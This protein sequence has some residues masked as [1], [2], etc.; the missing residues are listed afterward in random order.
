MELIVTGGGRGESTKEIDKLF[1]SKLDKHKPLL[2]IPIAID[3]IKHPYSECLNWLKGTFNQFGVS[4]YEMWI[5]KDLIKSK[6]KNPK[7]YSGIYIGGG[8]T[9][10]L[11]FKLKESGFWDFLKKALASDIPI[12]GSSAGAA[13]FSKTISI[14]LAYDKNW[15]NLSDLNGMN[16]IS[17]YEITCHFSDEERKLIQELI[18][19]HKIKHL[20]AL[21]EKNAL[22]INKTGIKLIGK[23]DASLFTN[24]LESK[25]LLNSF[26]PKIDFQQ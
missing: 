12:Y 16:L 25:I 11:L 22:E 6:R 3:S 19:K 15:N 10:Y 20:I 1:A 18:S 13:I 4:N 23:E 21:S 26:I 2:Y 14:P 17:G 8:N 9:P 7:N 5:E 24:K